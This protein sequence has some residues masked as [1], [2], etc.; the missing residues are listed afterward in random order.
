VNRIDA[1][2]QAKRASGEKALIPF[3][4]GGYPDMQTSADLAVAI[5]ESGADLIEIG[6]PF[7]DPIADGPTIQRSSKIALDRGA[8]LKKV[9]EAVRS[10]RERSQV[11]LLLF[12]ALNPFLRYGI[13]KIV[14][15]AKAA[16][17]DGF[18][19]PDSPPEESAQIEKLCR[20]HEMPLVYLAAPTSPPER[21]RMIA[22]RT[23][24]FLYYVAQKGVTGARS[25]LP[26]DL[27]EQI[28]R[29]RSVSEKPIAVGFGISKPEHVALVA[30]AAD[31]VIVG[32]AL[33]DVI[34][35]NEGGPALIAKAQ[36]YVASLAAAL[37]AGK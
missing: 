37:P 34:S 26:S 17:A 11:P 10:I 24:G 36:E 28:Q 14:A 33:I 6:V 20:E 13:E 23:T 30:K 18:L 5:A 8:T 31:G 12:G 15:D 1:L 3:L 9:L 22:E 27:L 7:S 4:T 16:G 2:F 32:S 25:E 29:L 19:I 21:H 35:K